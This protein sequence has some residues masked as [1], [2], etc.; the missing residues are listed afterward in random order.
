M[1][2]SEDYASVHCIP[3]KFLQDEISHDDHLKNR[4]LYVDVC[5]SLMHIVV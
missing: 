5:I 2:C 3:S 1:N 4:H